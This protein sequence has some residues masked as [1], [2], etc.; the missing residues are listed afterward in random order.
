VL[1]AAAGIASLLLVCGALAWKLSLERETSRLYLAQDY[2]KRVVSAAMKLLR[3]EW[4][5]ATVPPPGAP[6]R[7]YLLPRCYQNLL[8]GSG[9]LAA[10]EAVTELTGAVADLPDRFE[11]YY[12]RA[13]GRKLLGDDARA[14][15]DLRQCLERKPSFL[16]A[17]AVLSDIEV[18]ETEAPFR[19]PAPDGSDL[20]GRTWLGAHQAMKREAWV[21]AAAAYGELLTFEEGMKGELFLGSSIENLIRR[22]VALMETCDF[23]GAK[24]D[25]W[26]ARTVSRRQW[27]EF[28]EPLLFLG[29]V[30]FLD[31]YPSRTESLFLGALD[32][33]AD[34][35][36]TALWMAA[37]YQSLVP[38]L[39][40]SG[41]LG[42]AVA[43]ARKA[44]EFHAEDAA[45]HLR[46][47]WTLLRDHWSRRK[48]KGTPPDG[49]D[50]LREIES[51]V[52]A[53]LARGANESIAYF[54]W[55]KALE[56]QGKLELARELSEK[57]ETL[58]GCGA[59]SSRR[60]EMNTRN[61][62]S[63]TAV[64]ATLCLGLGVEGKAQQEPEGTFG[65]VKRLGGDTQDQDVNSPF[66]DAIGIVSGDGLTIAFT[67]DRPGGSGNAD[68]YIADRKD[69]SVPFTEVRNVSEL[70]TE[71]TEF[72]TFLSDD[73]L[74]LYFQFG[75]GSGAD[76]YGATRASRQQP[77]GLPYPMEGIN[78]EFLEGGLSLTA[79]GREAYFI[80]MRPGGNGGR[81]IWAARRA[82][83]EEAFSEVW[84]V[85]EVNTEL[86]EAV[87]S[88]SGDGLTLFWSDFPNSGA[89]LGGVG[90]ADIWYATRA[91]P[92]KQFGEPM[93]LGGPINTGGN[94][95]WIRVSPRWPVDGSLVYFDRCLDV[96]CDDT[97]IYQ[98]TWSMVPPPRFHR[99]DADADGKLDLSDGVS[100][101]N[102]LF[103]GGGLPLCMDAADA[104]DDGIVDLSDAV[105]IF[106]Y[107]FLGKESPPAPG[108][109]ICGPDPTP[110][111]LPACVYAA[112]RC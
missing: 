2:E 21:E 25:F 99:G 8:T 15:D 18:G 4:V 105:F 90:G 102:H 63:R 92:D 17:K 6:A 73:G 9:K 58:L 19:S 31:G 82:P 79:D 50:T 68:I 56:A 71:G 81:D 100:I 93:N 107:L 12:Y 23:E 53:A 22:G 41:R 45:A 20:W 39:E 62:A 40:R 49:P 67:S 95:F 43:A 101:L 87:P 80:S 84:N 37:V 96:N 112:P 89:R 75:V 38:E 108:P 65:D 28:L 34:R 27:G 76:M 1:L 70:N 36:M 16:P 33:S 104:N 86:D 85:E 13:R 52:A 111:S 66:L 61:F 42:E 54:L 10:E 3:G 72:A 24:L 29:K 110:D 47:G 98:A 64:A 55:S 5:L 44:V 74:S 32:R 69:L 91:A 59:N 109:D 60:Q 106:G 11:G 14:V 94:D 51:I 46:L 57:A 7:E 35:R 78:S 48:A 88:I 77:F 26:A 30:Y 83:G 103:L 97:D